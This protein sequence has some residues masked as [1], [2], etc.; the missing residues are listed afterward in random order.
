MSGRVPR[1]YINDVP[2][3]GDADPKIHTTHFQYLGIG[4][5]PSILKQTYHNGLNDIE[6]VGGSASS[7]SKA[8]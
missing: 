8:K 6:H 1:A 4:G 7:N 5:R 2:Q 3:H